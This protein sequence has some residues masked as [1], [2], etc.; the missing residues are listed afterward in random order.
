MV[1][2]KIPTETHDNWVLSDAKR[3]YPSLDCLSKEE[4]NKLEGRVRKLIAFEGEGKVPYKTVEAVERWITGASHFEKRDFDNCFDGSKKQKIYFV[5]P[6]EGNSM[7]VVKEGREPITE[8]IHM[9][10]THSDTPH[11]R[12]KPRAVRLEW[13]A[14]ILYHY[15]GLRLSGIIRGGLAVHHWIG[16]QVDVIGYISTKQGKREI[17][18]P[19]LIGDYSGHVDRRESEEVRD[20]F[21]KERLVEIITGHSSV[22]EFLKRLELKSLDELSQ[23]ALYAVPRNEVL[24]IDEYNWRLLVG[25][26][27]DDKACTFSAVDALVKARN[28]EYTSIVWI[29]DREEVGDVSPG[30]AQGSFFDWV[31]DYLID[32]QV[33]KTGTE[34]NE[35][36]KRGLLRKSSVL[37]GDVNIAPYGPDREVMDAES[38]PKVGFGTYIL[39]DDLESSHPHFIRYLRELALRGKARGQNICHMISGDFYNQDDFDS[40]L[41]NFS[42]KDSLLSR[43]G[44]YAWVGIPCASAHTHN[45]IICPADEYWTSRLYRRF[46]ESDAQFGRE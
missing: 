43:V 4:L 37:I 7:L 33:E 9:I 2:K 17:Q 1:H 28:P 12:V 45:E 11:V 38:A 13:S 30:G 15:L 14:D 32:K 44:Q 22:A 24:P 5:D 41:K 20:A 34:I 8:G 19:G 25:Y 27:Q 46:L 42:G 36:Q 26:G 31:L 10:M 18:F 23:A 39:G 3:E 40:W 21:K 35:R 16:Q 29:T 6:W